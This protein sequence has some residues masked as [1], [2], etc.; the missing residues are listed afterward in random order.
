MDMLQRLIDYRIIIII[1]IIIIK[2]LVL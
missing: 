2:Q 1:I